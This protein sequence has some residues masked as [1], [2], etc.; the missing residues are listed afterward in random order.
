MHPRH[1]LP[2]R[3]KFA[4]TSYSGRPAL[5]LLYVGD[6]TQSMQEKLTTALDFDTETK[7]RAS[8]WKHQL[9]ARPPMPGV[10]GLP[11]PTTPPSNPSCGHS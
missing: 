11:Y 1:H 3:K 2:I 9:E 10:A 7:L 6:E 8:R 5:C 4:A